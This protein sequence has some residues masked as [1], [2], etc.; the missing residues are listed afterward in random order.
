MPPYLRSALGAA[1]LAA[2][3]LLAAVPSGA[4]ASGEGSA[5]RAAKLPG[6]YIVIYRGSVHNPGRKTDRLERAERFHASHNYGRALKGFAARLSTRQLDQLR[7]DPDVAVV[8]PDRVVHATGV[9]PL[10]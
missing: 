10:A 2:S 3:A 5:Q 4:G 6:R 8:T 7:D 9:V 1:A